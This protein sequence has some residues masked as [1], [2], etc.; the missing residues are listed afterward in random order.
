[1]YLDKNGVEICV[2]DSV[3]IYSMGHKVGTAKVNLHKDIWY[4]DWDGDYTDKFMRSLKYLVSQ[5]S[6]EVIC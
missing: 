5:N 2:G 3:N 6:I 4:V 1:M